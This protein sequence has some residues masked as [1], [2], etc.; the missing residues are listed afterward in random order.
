[1]VGNEQLTNDVIGCAI[2]VHREL[3]PGLL[4]SIYEQCLCEELIQANIPPKRQLPLAVNYKG[5]QLDFGYRIDILVAS[6]LVLELKCV[7][8]ILELHKAQVLTYLK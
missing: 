5:K 2:E 3:G 8:S 6:Q 7:E 1:M 4:E